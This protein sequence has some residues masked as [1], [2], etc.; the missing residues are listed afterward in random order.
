DAVDVRMLIKP[1][2]D[3]GIVFNAGPDWAVDPEASKSHLRL[4][5]ALPTAETIRAGVAAFARV[6]YEQTGIP[7]QSANIRH[8]GRA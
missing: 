3:A 5:F 4:C 6:C 1:A 2:A 7:Q 8:G